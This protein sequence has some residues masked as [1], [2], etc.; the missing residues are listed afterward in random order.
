MKHRTQRLITASVAAAA[1]AVSTAANAQA[2]A[3]A[4]GLS[5]GRY[6]GRREYA[7]Y[8]FVRVEA[9]VHRHRLSNVRVLEYPHDNG[10]SRY[11]NGVAL[12]YLIQE[13]VQA[14]SHRVDL[15][16]GATFTSVAF[17]RSLADALRRA[18][19]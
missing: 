16:S 4:Y 19:Q 18:G 8:G 7:Y 14:Q 13:A 9:L 15:I 3:V 2:R 10:T 1:L 11:I 5:D 17:E 12:P 6:M